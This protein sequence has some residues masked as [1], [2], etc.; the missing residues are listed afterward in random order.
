MNAERAKGVAGII[1]IV[2]VLAGVFIANHSNRPPWVQ[3][4]FAAVALGQAGISIRK[5]VG[6]T[7]FDTDWESLL[8]GS[9]PGCS[10]PHRSL[11]LLGAILRHETFHARD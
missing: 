9:I 8:R 3:L 11:W 1:G 4:G 6:P 10:P 2:L 7:A 5:W